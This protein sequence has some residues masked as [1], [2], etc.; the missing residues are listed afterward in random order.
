M[1]DRL[2]VAGAKAVPQLVELTHQDQTGLARILPPRA[3]A[4]LPW[5]GFEARRRKA[6]RPRH[7]P[8]ALRQSSH[9]FSLMPVVVK[10][11]RQDDA[12]PL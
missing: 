4:P 3:M 2:A 12:S 9:R 10:R 7:T 5:R 11:R 1:A 8:A 6:Y